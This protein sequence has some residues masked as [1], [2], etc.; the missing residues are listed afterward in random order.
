MVAKQ[1]PLTV[2]QILPALDHGGVERGT[3][4]VAQALVKA[5]HR[6]L[7]VSAGGRMVPALEASGTEHFELDVGAKSVLTLRHIAPLARLLKKESVDIVHARSR[8]PAWI[9]YASAK[10][11]DTA[12]RPHFVTTVH[13]FYSVSRYSAIMTR[14][15]RVIAV[16]KSI[17]RYVREHYPKVGAQAVEV[18]HRGIDPTAFPY[19]YKPDDDWLVHW[20]RNLPQLENQ[21]VLLLPGRVTRLK[22]HLTLVRLMK[23]LKS[24]G[25]P[26]H[27][28]IVGGEDERRL[29]YANEVRNAIAAASLNDSISWLG[30]REDI[31]EIYAA[32]NLVLSLSTKPESFGRTVLEALSLG[33]PVAGYDH[34]GVGEIL[35]TIFPEGRVALGDED[36][37]VERVM[38]LLKNP[39]SVAEGH[40]FTLEHMTDRTLALY[41]ALCA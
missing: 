37:L 18:I 36:A 3:V 31:R 26:V 14:G 17:E 21:Q 22:G 1:R 10:L 33:V 4:E 40:P 25:L 23:A 41:R 7:V 28:I 29:G 13:G 12:R 19:G 8:L 34:G 11:L 20:R 35:A 16:S 9:A 39:I 27:A 15:E 2:L 6:S 5:G 24:T 30:V 38:S 32:S